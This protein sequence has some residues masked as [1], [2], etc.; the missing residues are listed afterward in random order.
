VLGEIPPS[1]EVHPW[2]D[3]VAILEQADAFLTHAGMGGSSE[4]LWAGTPMLVAPQATDQFGNADRLVELGVALR[5]DT[6]GST[7]GELRSALLALPQDRIREVRREVRANGGVQRA[8]DL[9][10]AELKV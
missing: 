4:G 5:V 3:Q 10:E 6:E 2:V 9:V 7:A 1:V 8:A